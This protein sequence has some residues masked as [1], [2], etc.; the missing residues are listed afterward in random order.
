MHSNEPGC[1]GRHDGHVRVAEYG[2]QHYRDK[3]G[4]SESEAVRALVGLHHV[5]LESGR[6]PYFHTSD[7]MSLTPELWTASVLVSPL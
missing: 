1:Y 4:S 6:E 7:A 2:E 5:P 3:S